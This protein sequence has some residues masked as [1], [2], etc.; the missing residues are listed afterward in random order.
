ME[1]LDL[2][3]YSIFINSKLKGRILAS[4]G[5]KQGILPIPIGFGCS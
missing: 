4:I 2:V 1:S 3:K 5:L